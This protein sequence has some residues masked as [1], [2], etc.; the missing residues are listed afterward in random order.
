M[1]INNHKSDRHSILIGFTS[2][3]IYD[4]LK[5]LFVSLL[6]ILSAWFASP[7]YP[8]ARF[9]VS[10]S[11]GQEPLTVTFSNSSVNARSWE[12]DFGD[13][14][15][16]REQKSPCHI[17]TKSGIYNAKL[18]IKWF[19]LEGNHSQTIRVEKRQSEEKNPEPSYEYLEIPNKLKP[20]AFQVQDT[21]LQHASQSTSKNI[22]LEYNLY[23]YNK[24]TTKRTIQIEVNQ[25]TGD[26]KVHNGILYSLTNDECG[27]PFFR[28]NIHN[29]VPS[30][31]VK[32]VKIELDNF[33]LYSK[34][35][36]EA[37]MYYEVYENYLS[38]LY[39]FRDM[40]SG[41]AA[42]EYDRNISNQK[43]ICESIKQLKTQLINI[44]R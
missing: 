32:I 33:Y 36:T 29:D 2:N 28:E 27:E 20:D 23:S 16:D 7:F 14:K 22:L 5:Y 35:A 21:E 24:G 11:E 43:A 19:F 34:P 42:T 12:W 39:K 4:V 40:C 41:V 30:L 15:T 1:D 10:P 13:G 37:R 9:D 31:L 18:T 44:D 38:D 26:S 17:Y 6:V 3:A 8:K 25:A